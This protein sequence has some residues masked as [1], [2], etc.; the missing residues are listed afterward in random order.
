MEV[1]GNS[2]SSEGNTGTST[3][4]LVHLTV[5]QGYLGGVILQRDDA[6]LNHLVVKIVAFTG[7]LTHAGK[8]RVTTMGP[9]NIV[10]QLHNKYSLADT[11]TA[12]QTDLSS[13]GV[14][15]QKV[16]NLDGAP[17]VNGLT[18]DV[19]DAAEGSGTHRDGDGGAH[20][21]HGLPPDQTLGTVHSNG[22][23]GALSQVLGH[24]QHQPGGATL[25]LKGVQDGRQVSVELHVHHSTNDCHD[26]AILGPSLRCSGVAAVLGNA[27]GRGTSL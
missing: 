16:H 22:A 10:D 23:H 6:S 4:G 13:L 1:L 20:I 5:H 15:G 24:L 3:G 27:Q 8:H 11:S 7:P 12:E 14:R 18:D 2:Q 21:M 19:D 9:S 25:H 26:L 17:L